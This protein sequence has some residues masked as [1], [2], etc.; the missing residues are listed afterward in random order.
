[1]SQQI[2]NV[3]A[4][5]NDGTGDTLRL[6]QQKANQNFTELYG[7]KLDSVVAGTNIT[8]DDTDPLNPI[9]SSSGGG[10]TQN[11]NEVLVEGNTTDGENISI[12]SGDSIILDNGSLLRKGTID[13]GFGGANG[14]AQICSV[15][16]ELKW[17][18]GRLYVMGDGGTTIREVSHNFTTTP[19][20]TDDITKGFIVGSRWLLDNGTLYVCTDNTST[21]A[22]WELQVIGTEN[23]QNVTDLGNTTTNSLNVQ[24]G[25]DYSIVNRTNVTT[26]SDATGAYAFIENTGKLGINSG[27]FEGTIQANNLTANNVNLEFPQKAVGSYTIATTDDLTGGT[28][29]SVGLTMPS[30]FSVTNSPITSSGDIAVTGAGVASQYVRGDGTLANFPTS[31]GGGASVSYYLN[32]SVSQGTLGGNA[33]KEM[34]GTPI[35]GTGTDFTINAD[36]YI[37]QFI[38]DS[39]NP[40]KLLIPAGNWNFE[41]YFSA[42]SSGGT[43]RFYIELYKYNGTTFTLISSNSTQPENITGGTSI[44]LYL[45]TLAV[46]STVLLATDRLAIRFYVLHSGRTITMH[47]ENSHLSQIITTFSTGLNALNGLTEQSQY[48][49]TGTSGTDFA[50][51]SATDTHT[52][53]LP[54][55]SATNRGALS[56]A[57]W[58]TFNG[59]QD[60]LVSGTNI[61]TINGNSVLGSGNLLLGAPLTRQEFSFSGA[62]TFTLSSTPSDIYAVFVDGQEL[63]SSQYSFSGTTLTIA[64]TLETNDKINILYTPASVGVLEY[65][66]K[67]QID[68]FLTNSNIE[69]IIGQA[70]GSISGYLSSTDWTTFNNKQ[71]A[72]TL[73][74]NNFSGAAT[75]VGSTLNI[76][77]YEGFIP[78][79][80]GHETFRGANFSNNSTT[81]TLLGGVTM[82]TTAST[83]ARSVSST[84]F[85]SKQIRKGFFG[86]VVSAG[87]YTGFRGSALLFYLG[88]GFKYMC[89]VYISDTAFGS[90]CR[91][92]YG[93]AGQTTDLAYS[94]SV[95]VSSLT[96]IIGVGSDAADTNLQVFYNDATGT[97]TKIDLG[98]NFPANRTAGAALT[99]IYSIELYNDSASTE[100]KY[101][102]RNKET[103]SIAMGTLS[104]DLPLHTQGLNFFASRCMGAGVTN[105][106]QFDLLTLG[107]YSL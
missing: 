53:N 77:N 17:E 52:F 20:A 29:T 51:S 27:D 74:S 71:N 18:A 72:L 83:I 9:I 14:I 78:K 44:D 38:T 87:R 41:T 49:A 3:G 94:D 22:V 28:V 99:T 32:G 98:A 7:T 4:T 76:P 36:G 63:N 97:A 43:P 24:L 86:S 10:G 96:N 85:A 45:T 79:L 93:M 5:A 11:L 1:M 19:V 61:K 8:I 65:Y 12:S 60:A 40:N 89:D 33:Y 35:I 34:D 70:S 59:K 31:S 103:G 42:S 68:S 26:E 64:D 16:Y 39:G 55:A 101:C 30:A 21:A 62:Q 81:D 2:I 90:G 57:N 56:S 80:K 69:S 25:D 67:A 75:L 48:F 58:S 82:A 66:T 106:G 46:P 84:N 105:T 95:L 100:V 15:G 92:F 6:S 91:Q 102:V 73:T 13:A 37:T 104:S 47:T 107:V 50:I 88:G 23:L 54:T